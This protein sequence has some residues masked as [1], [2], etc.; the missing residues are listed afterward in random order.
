MSLRN[1]L[2][3][4]SDR[5]RAAKRGG[6]A[7]VLSLDSEAAEAAYAQADA[8]GRSAEAFEHSREGFEGMLR[9]MDVS[10]RQ[11]R[12]LGE[13]WQELAEAG[14]PAEEIVRELTAS[15]QGLASE[16]VRTALQQ[17][18]SGLLQ[19]VFGSLADIFERLG[20]SEQ[21]ARLQPNRI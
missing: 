12:D 15:L 5:A 3:H 9:E 2:A 16:E 17:F 21:A 11:V 6:G 13:R 14:V 20:R 10:E 19:N 18:R 4:E 8:A 1:Y 7:P